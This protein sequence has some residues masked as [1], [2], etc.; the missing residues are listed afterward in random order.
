VIPNTHEN[1]TRWLK[2]PQ[3]IKP[4]SLMPDLNLTDAEVTALVAYLEG[5]P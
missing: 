5:Q 1:L 3:A 4:G 2:D